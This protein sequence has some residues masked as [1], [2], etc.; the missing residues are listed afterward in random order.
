MYYVDI[1]KKKTISNVKHLHVYSYQRRIRRS[2]YDCL[3]ITKTMYLIILWLFH[4]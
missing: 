3:Y 4:Y 1:M 2:S